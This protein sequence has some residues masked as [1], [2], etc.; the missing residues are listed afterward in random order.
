[1]SGEIKKQRENL[2]QI[3][4][5]V[6]LTADL[7]VQKQLK[8]KPTYTFAQAALEMLKD[9]QGQANESAKANHGKYWL[10][11]FSGRTICSWHVQ[12]GTPLMV[13]KERGR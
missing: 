8:P 3:D 2:P 9:S 4:F 1:M 6:K 5:H 13:L 7:W 11:V 12:S 10:S